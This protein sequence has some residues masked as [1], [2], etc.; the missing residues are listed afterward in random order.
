MIQQGLLKASAGEDL[1][2]E[3]F[4]KAGLKEEEAEKLADY[5]LG[6]RGKLHGEVFYGFFYEDEE[7]RPLIERTREYILLIERLVA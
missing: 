5:F 6:V 1:L 4:L 7:H 3:L 2:D